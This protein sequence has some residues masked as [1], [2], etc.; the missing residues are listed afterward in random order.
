MLK[1]ALQKSGRL[2]EG[3]IELLAEC[4]LKV[5]RSK[6]ALTG[7]SSGFPAELLFL[8][9]DDIPGYVEDGVADMGIVGENIFAEK[10][11]KATILQRLGFSKCRLS[12]AVP[13]GKSIIPVRAI[14]RVRKWPP[15]T[16]T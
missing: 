16:L 7:R 12:L 10:Q 5:H 11:T 9:D 1:I 4:G 3:S 15:P 8:R 6:N 14:F 13:Q 2:Y